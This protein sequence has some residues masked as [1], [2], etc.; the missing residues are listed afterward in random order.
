MVSYTTKEELRGFVRDISVLQRTRTRKSAE[1]RSPQGATF[2]SHSSRDDDLVDG[3]I[4]I[5]ENHGATVYLD[6]IDP[7]LPPYTSKETAAKLKTRI[8][9]S[10]KFVL[11]ATKNS[12]ESKWVPW[13]LGLA[14]GYKGLGK[15]ALFPAVDAR[16]E[17]SWTSWEYMG[18]Y[19]RIVWGKLKGYEKEVWMVLD[20]VDNTATEL[21]A[22]LRG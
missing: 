22:W 4:L 14:D 10:R 9:Q 15:I 2:L 16:Y 17:T 7:E 3:A 12:K 11:L 20:E 21:S 19:D 8:N 6:K 5:L 1:E 18:L 13:E